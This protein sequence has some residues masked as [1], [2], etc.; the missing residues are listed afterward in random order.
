MP[1][2]SSG[3]YTLPPSNPVVSGT[4]IEADWANGTMS[5][6]AL[7]LNG[8]ITR[9]GKL[10][11]LA[12]LNCVQSVESVPSIYFGA[13]NNGFGF[14]GSMGYV[15][16][17]GTTVARFA[18]TGGGNIFDKT[19]FGGYIKAGV[20][21]AGPYKMFE[22]PA[23]GNSNT[24]NYNVTSVR[25]LMGPTGANEIFAHYY[26]AANARSISTIYNSFLGVGYDY[27]AH[28]TLHPNCTLLAAGGLGAVN[29]ASP[30][31][32]LQLLADNTGTHINGTISDISFKLDAI[33]YL[34]VQNTTAIPEFKV[35]PRYDN[36][37]LG[38]ANA[39]LAEN[40]PVA[41]D[42]GKTIWV[43]GGTVDI[44]AGVFTTYDRIQVFN[45]GSIAAT[46]GPSSGMGF[47]VSGTTN[48]VTSVPLPANSGALLTFLGPNT[49]VVSIF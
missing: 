29:N 25:E 41:G 28:P 9:D 12:P 14:S 36:N 22:Q 2:D 24:I 34:R 38:Y 27:Q 18:A 1:R 13:A 5:D 3:N 15:T 20:G 32:T 11:M 17:S 49:A 42:Q 23:A 16:C 37:K 45:A 4:V 46:I 44:P 19:E 33:E 10:N 48:G 6:I 47:Y 31:I 30:G 21:S 26:N 35:H 40:P 39:A 43:Q 8:V 7:Q